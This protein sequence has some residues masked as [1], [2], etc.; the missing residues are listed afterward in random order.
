MRRETG[1]F[2]SPHGRGDGRFLK[3]ITAILSQGACLLGRFD[4]FG[5]DAHV[6]DPRQLDDHPR[7]GL[8]VVSLHQLVHEGVI[9]FQGIE[10]KATEI[11]E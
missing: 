10:G 8:C 7:D 6:Q 11:R 2:I 9:D 5:D 1:D 3:R 4:A